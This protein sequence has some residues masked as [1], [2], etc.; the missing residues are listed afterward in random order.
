MVTF[1]QSITTDQAQHVAFEFLLN[2][3][4]LSADDQ[5]WFIVLD[6]RSVGTAWFIVEIGIAGLP[7]VWYFQVFDTG[8]C[9]PNYTF[10]TPV[11]ASA[12]TTGL[13]FMPK[14]IAD[15]VQFERTSH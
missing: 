1:S 14:H 3:W 6:C 15:V 10:K 2:E 7:D 8:Y 9:D 11:A 12:S 4:E 13:D 5:D